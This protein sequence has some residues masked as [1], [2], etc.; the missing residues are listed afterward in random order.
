M[1][2][3]KMVALDAYGSFRLVFDFFLQENRKK[4]FDTD[5][6]N[7]YDPNL[8]CMITIEYLLFH[9][10][11]WKVDFWGCQMTQFHQYLVRV[12]PGKGL[13]TGI[14]NHDFRV[15]PMGV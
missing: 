8:P 13:T 1:N 6:G 11:D 2:T 15:V 14:R 5:P 12:I 9:N 4:Q 10:F 3:N 7:P